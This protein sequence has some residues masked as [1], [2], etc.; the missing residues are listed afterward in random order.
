[1]YKINE[2]NK[3]YLNKNK[4]IS[5]MTNSVNLEK[6]EKAHAITMLVGK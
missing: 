1:M 5:K 4:R 3:C 2:K 6:W